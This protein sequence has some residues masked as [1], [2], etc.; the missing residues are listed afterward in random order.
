MDR[1]E[2]SGSSGSGSIPDGATYIPLKALI[3][4]GIFF[5]GGQKRGWYY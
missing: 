1:I 2:D 4:K 5:I 3:F